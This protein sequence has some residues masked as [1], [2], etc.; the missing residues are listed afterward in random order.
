M[1]WNW[2][3][4]GFPLRAAAAAVLLLLLLLLIYAAAERRTAAQSVTEH[5]ATS[6]DGEIFRL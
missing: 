6:L 1:A 4:I 3:P 2:M 5:S